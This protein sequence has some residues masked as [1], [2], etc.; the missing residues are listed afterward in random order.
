VL[1]KSEGTQTHTMAEYKKMVTG[2]SF[3]I[4]NSDQYYE[5]PSASYSH[6]GLTEQSVKRALFL[7]LVKTPSVLE[8]L[9]FGAI[10]LHWMCNK[11]RIIGITKVAV[12][13]ILHPTV[14]K[15][16]SG[17]VILIPGMENYTMLKLYRTISFHSCIGS[18]KN[19]IVAQEL[20]E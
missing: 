17:V 16:V 12:I 6:E 2:E 10:C 13:K 5:L 3:P 8:K 15:R 18:V 7:H 11:I 20:S 14:W 1:S 4:N 9:S 19:K